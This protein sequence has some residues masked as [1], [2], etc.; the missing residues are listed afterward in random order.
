MP[1]PVTNEDLLGLVTKSGVADEKRLDAYLKRGGESVPEDPAELAVALVREGILTNFQVQQLLQGKWR[2]FAIGNYKVLE[3]LGS[4]GMGN[5]YL[6]EHKVMRKRVAIKVLATVSAENPEALKRFYREARAAAALDHPNIVRAHDVGK[7]DKLH[8]LVMDYV[9]GSSLENIIRRH[10]PMDVLRACHYIRQ[11]AMGLHFAHESGL[12]HRDIKPANLILDRGGSL[13]VLDMGVARFAQE[14]DEVLTKGPLGTAD[15]LAP[16][17]ALDSHGAD[18]RADIY[19]LGATFY[20]MLTA[21]PPLAE[22]KTVAQKI[23]LLQTK[24]PVPIS[25]FRHDVPPAVES[26][27]TRMMAKKPELR[28]QSL[29]E[30]IEDLEPL[31]EKPIPPPPDKEMPIP[32]MGASGGDGTDVNLGM[33]PVGGPSGSGRKLKPAR[34]AAAPAS[35]SKEQEAPTEKTSTALVVVLSVLITT[36]VAV[37]VWWAFLRPGH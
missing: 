25:E 14:D 37:G 2:G 31:T 11:G 32:V 33:T 22:G 35:S 24:P 26:I 9:D 16:E 29:A 28:Y 5:V 18:R 21:H 1:P 10:G 20:F 12:I 7:E 6:C 3:R 30:L 17:Q 36:A 15:Y 13:K 8:F 27:I 23:M 19:S 34:P 4:G